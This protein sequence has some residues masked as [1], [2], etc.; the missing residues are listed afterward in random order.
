MHI[1][2]KYMHILLGNIDFKHIII[3]I[4]VHNYII[5]IAI[6]IMK[7]RLKLVHVYRMSSH[8]VLLA[9]TTTDG[10]APLLAW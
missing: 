9:L 8:R 10:H 1:V 2:F 4:H 3:Y 7:N 5:I 6:T